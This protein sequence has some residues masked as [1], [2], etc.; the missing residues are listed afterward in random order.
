MNVTHYTDVRVSGKNLGPELGT[1][2][3][4]LAEGHGDGLVAAKL[5]RLNRSMSGGSTARAER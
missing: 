5:D 2:L 4:L 3:G 1:V